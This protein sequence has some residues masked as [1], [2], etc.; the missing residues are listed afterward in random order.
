VQHLG[1]QVRGSATEWVVDS[2]AGGNG[3]VALA[4]LAASA[5]GLAVYAHAHR[6][7]RRETLRQHV[8]AQIDERYGP[9]DALRAR[10]AAEGVGAVLE[11]ARAVLQRTESLALTPGE[12]DAIHAAQDDSGI[13]VF[14][15][16]KR[17]LEELRKQH[18]RLLAGLAPTAPPAGSNDL[19]GQRLGE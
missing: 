13:D 3:A 19:P 7:R 10:A 6:R 5:L 14:D 2:A 12:G 15:A 16:P 1:E 11:E 8:R 17:A 18:R 4:I 9:L